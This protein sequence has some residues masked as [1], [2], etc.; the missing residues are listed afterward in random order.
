MTMSD[1]RLT[2]LAKYIC[3]AM[4]AVGIGLAWG[5]GGMLTLGQGL[6]FGLGAYIMAMHM[7]LDDAGP[8]GVPDFLLLYGS[9]KVPSWWEPFRSPVFTLVAVVVIPVLVA[10]LLGWAVFARGVR[11]AY[12]AI[13]SQAL[14]AAFATLLVGQQ[15]TTGGTNGLNNFNGFFG[16]ALNDPANKQML[17]YIS[18]F[19]LLGMVLVARWI[20]HSFMGQLLVAVRDQENRVKFLGYEPA[21]IKMFAYAVSALFA[22]IAG[23]LFV[24]IVGIIS[25][26]DVGVTP[27][28]LMLA[29][30]VIGGRTTLLGPVLG[31]IGLRFIE[32]QL[33]ES[34]PAFWTYFEGGLFIVVICFLP[35]GLG[36]LSKVPEWIRGQLSSRSARSEATRTIP[37]EGR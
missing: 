15:K 1:F 7:K 28:I 12:F 26:A 22:G 19:L 23:A 21:S 30:V 17:Y 18:A 24:P 14:V 2:L 36:G 37:A 35:L 34:Y 33:S 29:G 13:L 6:F 5:Q 11:G 16:F 4:I 3:F 25:P 10:L 9:G 27:S 20:M 8:G 32:T 31:T